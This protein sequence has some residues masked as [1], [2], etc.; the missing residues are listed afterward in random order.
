MSKALIAALSFLFCGSLLA[1][2][3]LP[4]ELLREA[5]D[6]RLLGRGEMRW[7]GLHLY[8]AALWSSADPWSPRQTY[9]L[10]IEYARDIPG[11]RLVE[12]SLAEMRRLGARD[13]D[14][15]ARWETALNG[16]FPDVRKGDRIVGVHLPG[17]GA[18]FYHQGRMT[19]S[20]DD[21]EFA[22]TFFAI[23]LDPRT[24]EPSLRK[25]LLG[26]R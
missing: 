3:Q 19:G 9:A 4:A 26:L 1:N 22:E 8:D 11:K 14:K 5:P 16:V 25:A 23:W 24:R 17:R 15:L 7:F 20:I 18:T 12:S 10:S 21:A 13:E 2:T 6:L